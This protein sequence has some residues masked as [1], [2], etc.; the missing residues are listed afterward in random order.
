MNKIDKGKELDKQMEL[1]IF[2]NIKTIKVVE[3]IELLYKLKGHVRMINLYW[4]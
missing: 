1:V 3:Y 2:V 4:P